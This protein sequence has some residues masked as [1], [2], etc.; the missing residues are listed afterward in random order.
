MEKEWVS[1]NQFMKM[2]NIGYETAMRL[3]SGG[4]VEY[5]KLGKQYKIKISKNENVNK[6]YEELLKEN[7]ELKAYIKTIQN[8]L[9]QVQI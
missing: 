1:L 5:Q 4:K 8:V 6:Q 2:N 9:S 7:T 3:I